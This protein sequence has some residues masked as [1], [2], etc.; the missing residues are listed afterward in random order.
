M[1]TKNTLM[2][3]TLG[4]LAVMSVISLTTVDV[5]GEE[6]SKYKMADGTSEAGQAATLSASTIY[7]TCSHWQLSSTIAEHFLR[8]GMDMLMFTFTLLV[9]SGIAFSC[10]QF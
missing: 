6:N 7:F 9:Q 1:T 8:M 10:K 3:T 5:F 2:T 4:L